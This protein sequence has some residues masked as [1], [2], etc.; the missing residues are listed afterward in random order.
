[1]AAARWITARAWPADV[2]G[3]AAGV[4]PEGR[5]VAMGF[6]DPALVLAKEAGD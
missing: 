1:M 2:A 3:A 6:A 4:R 5:L